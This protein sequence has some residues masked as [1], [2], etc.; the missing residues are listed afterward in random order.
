LKDKIL[1]NFSDNT[2]DLVD[3]L[4]VCDGIFSN[5]KKIIE[6]NLTKTKTFKEGIITNS[7]YSAALEQGIKPNIIIEF[8]RIYGF[9]VD[10]QRDIRKNDKF[11][12][13]Y[14]IFLNEKKEVIETGEIL[15]ANLNLS[16]QDNNLYYF[17]N[18]Y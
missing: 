18:K 2:N 11:Q 16:G 6:K 1:I 9:Q 7:L 3:Y 8:A 17:D 14:E 10:F 4:F 12:I 5:T 13:M 15:F